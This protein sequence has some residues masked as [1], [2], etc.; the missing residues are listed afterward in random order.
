[1]DVEQET[2]TPLVFTTIGGMGEESKRFHNR[3][4]ELV[5]AKKRRELCHHRLVD[6][7][8]CYP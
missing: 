5:A 3:L 7:F 6:A 2:F 8:L 4:A 1:M